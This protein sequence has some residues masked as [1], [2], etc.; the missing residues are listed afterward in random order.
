L[1]GYFNSF[2][3]FFYFYLLSLFFIFRY[4]SLVIIIS[5][6]SLLS[7]LLS[8]FLSAVFK[9]GGGVAKQQLRTSP[10]TIALPRCHVGQRG[11]ASNRRITAAHE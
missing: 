7:F 1:V 11:K 8:V 10:L 2:L 9:A 6:L 5:I 3:S 4:I